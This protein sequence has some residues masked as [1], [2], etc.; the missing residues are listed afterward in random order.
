MHDNVM[1]TPNIELLAPAGNLEKLKFAID[2]GAD[3]VYLGGKQ[4]GLRAFA[5]NFTEEDMLAGVDY[6]HKRGKKVYATVNIFAHNEDLNGLEDYLLEL[7]NLGIDAIIASDPGVIATCQEVIPGMELHLSTQANC[8]N[9]K[10]VRFWGK[11]GITRVILA[12][13]LGLREI[14]EISTRVPEVELEAFVHGAMCIAYSGR[15]L[16]SNYLT[17]RD[18]NRGACSHPCRWKYYLMEEARPGEY[19]PIFE[20][21]QGTKI[22]SS[23]DLN[24]LEHLPT[25]IEAG[26]T[27]FKIE[28]RMKSA[29][30]VATVVRA[31]RLAINAYLQD[32]Q[33]YVMDEE[34]KAELG[35]AATRPFT[36][37]FY[38]QAP[39]EGA[40]TYGDGDESS[41]FEFV[42][43]VLDYQ[44][45]Y[46]QIEQRNHFQVGDE[47]EI[48]E[49][50][51]H[52]GFL[53]VEE[54]INSSGEKVTSAPHPKEVV[55]I[56]S[57]RPC[58]SMALVRKING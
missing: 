41:K 38:F 43:I 3:A 28:G 35:K 21:G 16:L 24:M 18:A 40:Q 31:Y 46:L 54:I 56:P 49:P 45:G 17:A 36:T 53:K 44:R 55:Q 8:T 5:G 20:D 6:A 4:Y 29:H 34:L 26:V 32:P 2:Y 10:S 52:G 12:R 50:Q 33:N 51:K 57:D 48:V 25:L 13:E 27:R 1:S 19:F 11:Q 22:M 39:D 42:G 47:L 15:C 9:W 14:S 7:K 23:K 37:G 58:S 30:Y